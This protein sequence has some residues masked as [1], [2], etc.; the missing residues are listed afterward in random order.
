MIGALLLGL[1]CGVAARMLVAGDAFRRMSGPM[2]WLAST[3][4]GLVGRHM[5]TAAY[6]RKQRE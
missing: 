5:D 2:S 6:P 3:G 4:L 1:F